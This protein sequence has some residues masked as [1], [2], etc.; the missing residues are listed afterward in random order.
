M[1]ALMKLT[2]S[3]RECAVG[4]QSVRGTPRYSLIVDIE[5]TDEKLQ[6]RIK[7]RTKMLSLSGCGVDTVQLF[8]QGTGIRINLSHRGE[9]VRAFAKVV[10]ST[11]V[12]GMGV[13]FTNVEREDQRVLENW[14]AEYLSIPI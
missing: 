3:G 8:P 13:A 2:H 4:H 10:Y 5:I 6:T 1:H 11:S 14:I 12:L 7:A 9:H